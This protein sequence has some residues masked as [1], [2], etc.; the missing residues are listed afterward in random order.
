LWVPIIHL[1]SEV[2][3]IAPSRIY[4]KFGIDIRERERE[5]RIHREIN[6]TQ[7]EKELY[8]G[9]AQTALDIQTYIPGP[10]KGPR[11]DKSNHRYL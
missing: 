1:S 5:R 8:G 4:E 11:R 6:K 10:G 7:P 3:L 2:P 9:A